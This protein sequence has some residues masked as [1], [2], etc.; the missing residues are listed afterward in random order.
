M[1]T[2]DIHS[3]SE[4]RANLTDHLRQIQ[5]T[6]RPKIITQNGKAAAVVLSPAKYD[7]LMQ[8]AEFSNDIQAIKKSINEVNANKGK[9]A[10]SA[11]RAIA[12]KHGL[13]LKR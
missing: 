8:K 12:K 3:M 6:G 2:D 9:E 4:H 11:L 10:K 5:E 1:R 13:D 7:E